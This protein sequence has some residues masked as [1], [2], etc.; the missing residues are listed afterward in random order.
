MRP[1]DS[2]MLPALALSCGL[3]AKVHAAPDTWAHAIGMS[4]VPGGA[5]DD[6]CGK[7]RIG[8]VADDL[9]F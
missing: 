2:S 3:S 9:A 7:A 6:L 5:N 1:L 8:A 4:S